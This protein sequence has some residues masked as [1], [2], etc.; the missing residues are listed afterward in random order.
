MGSRNHT[1]VGSAVIAKCL[2]EALKPINWYCHNNTF[3]CFLKRVKSTIRDSSVHFILIPLF[4]GQANHVK[5]H[6]VE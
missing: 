1:I 3:D 5:L 4:T 6:L 2:L